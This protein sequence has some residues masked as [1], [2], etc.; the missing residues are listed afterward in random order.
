[1]YFI[2]WA[3]KGVYKMKKI[4]KLKW[5]INGET[6]LIQIMLW[7]IVWKLFGGIVGYIAIIFIIGNIY[8]VLRSVVKL[9]K[10]YFED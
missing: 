9:G 1:M 4:D 3:G 6:G 2:F 7:I 8:T 10:D 5:Q